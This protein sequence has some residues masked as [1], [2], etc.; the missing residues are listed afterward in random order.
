V[1][2]IPISFKVAGLLS[3]LLL[4]A[5][6]LP[7]TLAP[8]Q[9]KQLAQDTNRDVIVILRDQ[10]P[11]L[12]PVRGARP[13]RAAALAEAQS[14]ILLDLQQSGAS[15]VR[16]FGLIN[17]VAATVSQAEAGTIWR[18]SRWCRPWRSTC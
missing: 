12:P 16:S 13:A 18:R 10:M 9:I 4:S 5:S 15:N 1:H 14:P 17:A 6:A 3:A 2:S 8:N 7:G 11:D